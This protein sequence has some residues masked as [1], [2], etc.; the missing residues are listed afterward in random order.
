MRIY[1]DNCCYNRPFDDQTQTKVR[2][3]TICKLAV[4]L[5]MATGRVEYAWSFMLDIESLKNSDVQRRKAVRR[6]RVS[7]VSNVRTSDAIRVRAKEVM[8]FGIKPQDAIHLAC[9]E[10][11]ACDWFLTVD[12][13]ILNKVE[14]LGNMRVAN[15]VEFIMEVEK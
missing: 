6:W 4:Q 14:K 2:V 3:E 5:M 8:Q 9:A 11:G 1:L 10:A 7:A 13:G 12:R 15:P